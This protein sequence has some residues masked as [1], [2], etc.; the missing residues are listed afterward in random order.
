M[1]YILGA[2]EK[3]S[4]E[5]VLHYGVK[6]M[7]WGVRRSDKELGKSS[8]KSKDAP[9]GRKSA[10]LA[11]QVKASLG[12]PPTKKQR[13]DNLAKAKQDFDKKFDGSDGPSASKKTK[14]G[15]KLTNQQKA[16]IVVGAAYAGVVA[17]DYYAQ[18]KLSD[19]PGSP[20]A[21]NYKPGKG[22]KL[23]FNP[24]DS[25]SAK[26]Y[27]TLTRQSQTEIWGG[28]G[29]RLK[30]Y[31][32]GALEREDISIPKGHTF[33]RL[34]KA[35]ESTFSDGKGTYT[36]LDMA[37]F[38]RY[39]FG[40]GEMEKGGA[41]GLHHVSFDAVRDVK[42]A[43]AKTQVKAMHTHLKKSNPKVTEFEALK[44][45]SK[46][47]GGGW[48]SSDPNVSGMFKELIKEGYAGI[49]D[50]MDAGVIGESPSVL[51]DT[52]AVG[53]KRSSVITAQ[54]VI[55]WGTQLTEI[56]NRKDRE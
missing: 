23:T 20:I 19:L 25:V 41:S 26:D 52:S 7:R 30:Y 32:K 54:Q 43:S 2:E 10:S 46:S 55:E 6:G 50:E 38:R 40:F 56:S 39:V 17:Y 29:G 13:A 4:P 48:F 11:D 18:K 1:T 8:S 31:T 3:P 9:K 24:G 15:L 27:M 21:S 33:H 22:L 35:A 53:S 34:S 49:I 45:L 42:I 51:F 47:A 12:P 14:K 36:T 16:L 44:E 5:D 37:D 28:A